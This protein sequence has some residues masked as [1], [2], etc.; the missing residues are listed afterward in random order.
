MLEQLPLMEGFEAVPAEPGAF[1]GRIPD[2]SKASAEELW[3][4]WRVQFA[5]DDSAIAVA[6]WSANRLVKDKA[7]S[8]KRTFY[9]I[10]DAF[11]DR[12]G[13]EGRRVREE[14]QRC[15]RCHEGVTDDGDICDHCDGYGVYRSRWL[16]L[17][18]FT[19][20]GVPYKLHSYVE[21]KVLLLEPAEDAEHFG[22]SFTEA[23]QSSLALPMTGLLKLLTYVAAALWKLHCYDGV[24]S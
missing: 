18:E 8:T 24:Y 7:R 5:S 13:S 11:I 10:K 23:E 17:H 2:W 14:K 15:F 22:T 9:S 3:R 12:Y 20:A 1:T 19:V 16:Y 4:M 6:V 21:P